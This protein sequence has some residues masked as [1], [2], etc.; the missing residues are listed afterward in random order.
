MCTDGSYC[1]NNDV[2]CC[3]KKEGKFLD[4]S[5][6]I[7]SDPY[8]TR[9]TATRASLATVTATSVAATTV[10][11][12]PVASRSQGLSAAAEGVIGA[13][14]GVLALTLV[15]AGLLVWR[16]RRQIHSLNAKSMSMQVS[17]Q[18]HHSY[19]HDRNAAMGFAP[20]ELRGGGATNS[21]MRRELES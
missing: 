4:P 16:K 7:I 3:S 2:T 12:A 11:A 21:P 17:P 20:V 9:T 6:N 10:H 8:T 19:P 13:L 14:A 18:V 1:C 15:A 5:G